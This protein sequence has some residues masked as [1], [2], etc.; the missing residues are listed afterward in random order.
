MTD[1]RGS[2]TIPVTETRFPL[3]LVV[4]RKSFATVQLPIDLNDSSPLSIPLEEARPLSLR[5][6]RSD[7]TPLQASDISFCCRSAGQPWISLEVTDGPSSGSLTVDRAPSGE[8]ELLIRNQEVTNL[9]TVPSGDQ[10][11]ELVHGAP[12]AEPKNWDGLGMPDDADL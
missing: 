2:F 10:A 6:E 12:G 5:V 4:S 9:F 1:E 11:A 3:S 7:G 8:L